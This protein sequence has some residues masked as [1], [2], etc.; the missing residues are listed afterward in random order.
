MRQRKPTHPGAILR[1]DVLPELGISI[2]AFAEGVHTSRQTIHKIL[3]EKKSITPEMALKIGKYVGNG[4]GVWLRM[5][6]AHDLY[7]AE[8]TIAEELK[9]IHACCA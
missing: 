7:I 4:P 2:S 1:E 6:Q 5:Q 8:L 9:N 3:A